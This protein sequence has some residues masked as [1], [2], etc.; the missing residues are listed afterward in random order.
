MTVK[1]VVYT[2]FNLL[3]I[4]CLVAILISGSNLYDTSLMGLAGG[5]GIA[6]LGMGSLLAFV[7]IQ[8][9]RREK[10]QQLPTFEGQDYEPW[11]WQSFY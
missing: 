9:R 11:Y 7:E 8:S 10:F 4:G 6:C 2:L 5:A 3:G 1:L